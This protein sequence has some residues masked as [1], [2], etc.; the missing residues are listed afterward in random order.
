[1]ICR[2][3]V[4][5]G[6]NDKLKKKILIEILT[7]KFDVERLVLVVGKEGEYRKIILENNKHVVCFLEFF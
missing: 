5:D 2:S 4:C 3:C 7:E 6:Q 1:M